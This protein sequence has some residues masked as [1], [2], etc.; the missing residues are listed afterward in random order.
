MKEHFRKTVLLMGFC[1]LLGVSPSLLAA[2]SSG[3]EAAEQQQTKRVTGTVSDAA[4]TIIG[5]NVMEKGTTNGVITDASGQ[6]AINVRPGATLVISYIGYTTREIR[7]GNQNTLDIILNEDSELL[8]EV[9]V[10]GYGTMKK[11]DLS[12]ASVSVGEKAIKSTIATNLDQALQGKAAGVTTVMTSGAPGSSMSINIRGQA[13]IN[14]SSS[15]LY[16]VDG[17]IWQGGSTTGN[18]LGLNLGNGAGSISPLSNLNPSDI[19]SM[20][21]LKDASATAIYGAQGS[22]GVVLITTKRGRSGEARFTYEGMVGWQEQNKRLDMMNLREYAEYS[23]AIAATTGGSQGTPEY[24]DPSLLGAGTDWQDAVFRPALMHQHTIS[25]E[26]GTDKVKYYV[27]GSYMDQEGTIIGT[28]FNRFSAR[29][30]LDAQ[31]KSWFK[32]GMNVM[33]SQTNEHLNVAEGTQGILTYSLQTPPDIPIYDAYGNFASQVREG[34]T[35]VNPIAMA[36]LDT[37]TLKRQKLNGSLFW[38]ITPLK[39][40]TWHAELGYDFG[41]SHSEA[42]QPTYDFGGGVRRDVN[43]IAWQKNT[44]SYWNLKNYITYTGQIGKHGF[45]AMVGQEASESNWDYIRIRGL[46]LGS[47]IVKNPQLANE[48]NQTYFD[49]FGD[50]S[51]A[52]F[53]TRETYNYDDRYLA[54]YTFRYDGSSAFGPDN[55]WAKFHSLAGSWRFTN[56]KFWAPIKHIVSNGKLRVGWGQTGNSN[57]GQGLWGATISSFPTGLGTAFKQAQIANPAVKWETQEQWNIGLDLS[58]LDD[59]INLTVDWY[60][61]RASDMLMRL[62]LPTYFGSRGNGNSALTAPMGNYGTIDNRGLEIS[63]NTHNLTG[64]LTWDTDFQISFNRNKLVALSGTDASAI[65]GYGQWSDVVSLSQIGKPLFQF[66][67]YVADGVYK[68]KQDIMDHLYGSL[69]AAFNR[70]STVFPGDMK[71]RDISGPAGTPDGVIDTH[72]RTIIGN[73]LPDFTFGFNN[74]FSYKGFDLTIFLQGSVGNDVFNALGRE[75]TGMGYWTNQLRDA[76]DYARLAPIDP[77]KQYPVTTGGVTINNWFEDAD[78]VVVTNPGTMMSRAGQGLPYNNTRI[79]S[80]YIEDGSYLRFKNIMLGYTLPK[81]LL[82]KV[83]LSNVRV[84]CN[85]QNLWTITGYSGFDPEVGANSQDA[86]GYTFGFDMGRYP[87]PRT[88]SFGANISF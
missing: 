63:L 48:D 62:Q 5:A 32:L 72:D 12:G 74:S 9:V 56:E 47:N 35:R 69:P 46:D 44:N 60:N 20:E 61:K 87:S 58:F 38:D 24:Q 73:P 7:V 68:D 37:N 29:M 54:T 64:E 53:F 33:Y 4:G 3:A 55:R 14:A 39:G 30:N 26:G 6:F 40:L 45:T 59:R 23:S 49:G 42:W 85:I 41:W 78:N 8:D 15:P 76:M 50:G 11:S 65:E 19:V 77:N 21:I 2:P 84:Y 1:S 86:T 75:L 70:Y 51:M 79:S 10:I 13:T 71:Y 25:A 43:S 17:V 28:D 67:G 16:V 34:Y 88:V 57:I 27:S 81:A 18:S 22:N 80:K 36:N 66:Y 82:R 52:S 31:L 83:G